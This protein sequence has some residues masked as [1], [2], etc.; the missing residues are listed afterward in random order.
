MSARLPAARAWLGLG[1]NLGD[2][3]ACLG[4]AVRE[5]AAAPDIRVTAVSGLWESAYVGPGEQ[6]PYLNACVEIETHLT[7]PALLGLCKTL[8][9]AHGRAPDTHLAPR[10]LDLDVLL[11]GDLRQADAEPLLPHPRL[12][13]RAFVLEPLAEIAPRRRLPD[14]GQTVTA[15]CAKIR[16]AG[17]PWIRPRRDP[18]W[19]PR[20][21][22]TEE[23]GSAAVAL[24]RR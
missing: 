2:R 16:R 17:G 13:E 22:D 8:E 21:A 18:A 20:L 19:P 11:Y 23:D 9:R 10:P 1:A 24:H 12:A 4:A 15:A 3:R 6:A 5:L 7:P 14:S